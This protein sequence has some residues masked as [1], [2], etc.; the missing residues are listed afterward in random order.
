MQ[1]ARTKSETDPA[2]P[3]VV[4]VGIGD[5]TQ[6]DEFFAWAWPSV[7]VI[8]DA[9]LALHEAFGLT[10]ARMSRVIGPRV[11]GSVFRAWR[12]GVGA[13]SGDVKMLAGAFVVARGRVVWE[14]RSEHAGDV[15]D[16]AAAAAAA[17]HNA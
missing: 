16:L 10:R 15:P 1:L 3:S 4:F 17:T 13:P 5:T 6:S 9:S 14:H 7:P 2:F 8:A 11:W 12:N